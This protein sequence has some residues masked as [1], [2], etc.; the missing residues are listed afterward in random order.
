MSTAIEV[1]MVMSGN[2]GS[3][4]ASSSFIEVHLPYHSLNVFAR[5]FI[6]WTLTYIEA[7]D[8]PKNGDGRLFSRPSYF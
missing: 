3:T 4:D 2:I 5:A 6:P 1:Y 8:T 7:W